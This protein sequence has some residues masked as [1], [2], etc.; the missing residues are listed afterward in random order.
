MVKFF[1]SKKVADESMTSPLL[2]DEQFTWLKNNE[3]TMP[4]SSS[5]SSRSP[6]MAT[7]DSSVT[8]LSS[9]QTL[10]SSSTSGTASV[11]SLRSS[12]SSKKSNKTELSQV[13]Q[14]GRDVKLGCCHIFGGLLIKTIHVIDALLGILL[15]TYGSLIIT[16]FAKPAMAISVI[17]L[18]L[19]SVLLLAAIMG[20]IGFHYKVCKRL[21]LALSAYMAPFIAFFYL[22]I[23]IA[24][25]AA[26]DKFFNYLRLH[27]DVLY[28]SAT[29]IKSLRDLLPLFYI[30]LLVLAVL[31]M[32]R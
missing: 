16:K 25:L 17:C 3:D 1:A 5:S 28:L 15:L 4:S 13:E 6:L 26:T 24:V 10:T 19:G 29:R 18:T 27:K 23:V 14:D 20:F 11:S 22:I 32:S 7:D 9:R 8:G 31:E 30:V 21:G 12:K 2:G